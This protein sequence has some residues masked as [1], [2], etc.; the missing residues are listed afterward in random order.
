VKIP[1]DETRKPVA[2]YKEY[3]LLQISLENYDRLLFIELNC[4]QALLEG[5]L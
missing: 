1:Q 4:S 3:F 2:S 5:H